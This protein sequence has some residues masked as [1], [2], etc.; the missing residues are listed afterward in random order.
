MQSG[1]WPATTSIGVLTCDNAALS[2]Q[3]II[4]M[5]DEV[6]YSIKQTGKNAIKFTTYAG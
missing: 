2:A 1:K 4:G 6:M 5:V 3:E